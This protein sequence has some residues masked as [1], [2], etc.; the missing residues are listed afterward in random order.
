[1]SEDAESFVE[2][3]LQPWTFNSDCNLDALLAVHDKPKKAVV[4][5]HGFAA[6]KYSL[7]PYA[8]I[9][10]DHGYLVAAYDARGHGESG[11]TLDVG[12]MVDDVGVVVDEL[13]DTFGVKSVGLVGLSMGGWITSMAAAECK[14]VKAAVVLSGAINP[15]DDL[16]ESDSLIKPL[17][18]YGLSLAGLLD[19]YGLD[20]TLPKLC[21]RI[22]TNK[23]NLWAIE[24]IVEDLSDLFFS[25]PGLA[26][27]STSSIYNMFSD[28]PDAKDYA[29][30]IKVPFLSVC[31]TEDPAIPVSAAVEMYNAVASAEK[32]LLVLSGNHSVWSRRFGLISSRM[33]RFFDDAL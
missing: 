12:A 24:M 26:D 7:L 13:Y 20:I 4:L 14:G 6:N 28:S 27:L 23:K 22:L 19:K 1:M 25:I 3:V 8:R 10:Y 9:L 5:V 16:Y 2:D 30:R 32:E 33:L 17:V 29:P 31:G 15:L 18:R 21:S 11:G